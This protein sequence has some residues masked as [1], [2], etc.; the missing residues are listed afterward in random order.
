M[1]RLFVTG[2][3]MLAIIGAGTTFSS[4][5]FN[6]YTDQSVPSDGFSPSGWMGDTSDMVFTNQSTDTPYSGTT[7]IEITYSAKRSQDKGWAG[8]Y[9][10]SSP[11]NWGAQDTGLDLKGMN[12][13]TFMARGKNGGE[14]IT[15]AK[16]GGI[17]FTPQGETVLFPDTANAS[18]GPIRLTKD[19]QQYK[20]NLAG[21]DLSYVNGGFCIVFD[22]NQA[23]R[24]QTLYL[25]DITYSYDPYLKEEQVR[26]DFP[27]YV[28]SDA[29]S[30]NNHFIPSGWMPASASSD[31]RLDVNWKINP[32]LGDSCIRT[33]Y[34]NNSGTRWAGI[35]WQHPANNWAM[36]PDVGFDLRGARRLIFWARGDKGGEIIEVFKAGGIFSGPHIDSDSAS[37]EH[38]RLTKYWKKYQ[39]DL[40]GKDLSYIIGGFCWATNIDVNNPEG[41][42]FYLDEIRYEK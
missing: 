33:E 12:K 41:I 31:L 36:I 28:Y 37:I 18:Y 19:W 42:T 16:V 2:L 29:S 11:N 35:Y 3:I 5:G 39:I 27:F 20:I 1:I 17:Q 26:I 15:L 38:I 21:K 25:D 24:E 4:E 13:L 6:I 40:M 32:F 30:L 14:V 22:A 9:W 34:R 7:C 10:Q 23:G 8:I